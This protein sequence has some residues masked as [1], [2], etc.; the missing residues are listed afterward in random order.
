MSTERDNHKTVERELN[1]EAL[2]EAGE[3]G[4]ERIAEQLERR[5]PERTTEKSAAE[6]SKEALKQATTKEKEPSH[7]EK[8]ADNPERR[9]KGPITKRQQAE[10][11]DRTMT[12]A[13]THMTPAERTFS[14]VIHN[15]VVEKTSEVVGSTVARPN[16]ILSGSISAFIIVLGVFLIAKHYGYPL[17]GA[18]TV[19]AFVIGW[20]IGIVYDFLRTMV[21]GGR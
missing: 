1:Q 15:P 2:A 17:S 16:A 13:R 18:E 5:S 8:L 10:A 14:K 9:Q 3:Q 20:L 19:I 4:R 11:F 7:K 21:T 12:D 6:L